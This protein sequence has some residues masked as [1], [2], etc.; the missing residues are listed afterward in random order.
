MPER[1]VPRPSILFLSTSFLTRRENKA[2]RGVQLFDMLLLEQMLAEPINVTLIAESTWERR[3]RDRI[4]L[5]GATVIRTPSL[6]KPL[7]NT[8]VAA[9]RLLATRHDAVVVGNPTRGLAPVI[10]LI[11]RRHPATPFTVL[12]HREVRPAFAR[13]FSRAPVT[14][15]CVNDAIATHARGLMPGARV[16]TFYGVADA[17]RFFPRASPKPAGEPVRFGVL[18]KL[19]NPWKGA[20][21]AVRAYLALPDDLRARCRLCLGSYERPQNKP[22]INEP[23]VEALDWMDSKETPGFL[24]TLD[25]LMVP[26]T[27]HETFSQAIVQGMLTGLP[28]IARD[29]PVLAEKL[30]NGA[31]IVVGDVGAMT[32]AMARLAQEPET[33]AA[34]GA[35]ARATALERYVWR[36]DRFLADYALGDAAGWPASVR[37]RPGS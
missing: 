37:V 15:V 23:G 14:V 24:R 22:R 3:L 29:M 19:D 12:A 26:S 31:G 6:I 16:E 28:V 21:D 20:D 7:W 9:P 5:S 25:V 4:D 27:S 18:G 30:D 34:M 2:L 32:A 36:T 11:R 35:A 13:A 10:R 17:D 1:N 8:L 33:R